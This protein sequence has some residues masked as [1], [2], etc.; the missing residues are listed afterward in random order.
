MKEKDSCNIICATPLIA[1]NSTT[2]HR[3]QCIKSQH[4]Q[5]FVKKSEL[6]VPFKLLYFLSAAR[7]CELQT[8]WIREDKLIYTGEILTQLL[9]SHISNF[10]LK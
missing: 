4:K 9:K 7:H 8:A 6:T 3:T 10:I 1:H 5:A 2:L